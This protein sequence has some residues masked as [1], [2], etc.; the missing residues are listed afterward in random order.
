MP[1]QIS[2][3][4]WSQ[5]VFF[6]RMYVFITK[7]L[8]SSLL[9]LFAYLTFIFQITDAS[10]LQTG[11]PH[12]PVY[13][14]A[15]HLL[16]SFDS[17]HFTF[18]SVYLN[19][20]PLSAANLQTVWGGI[21]SLFFFIIPDV[22][23]AQE[24]LGMNWAI[25]SL[26]GSDSYLYSHTWKHNLLRPGISLFPWAHFPSPFSYMWGWFP[27]LTQNKDKKGI[28]S[29]HLTDIFPCNF[30]TLLESLPY[31]SVN[32]LLH[33]LFH[34]LRQLYFNTFQI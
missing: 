32:W 30:M 3:T 9:F 20:L 34:I 21:N 16:S 22:V 19:N 2:V 11:F 6:I 7:I 5:R 31:I 25:P 13:S 8:Y 29:I 12:H 17:E 18:I 10:L 28:I 1:P 4:V 15:V 14:F 26:R 33:I 27:W 24:T 23:S